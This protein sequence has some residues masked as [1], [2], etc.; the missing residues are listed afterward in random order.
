MTM[1]KSVRR[2]PR[3]SPAG[4]ARGA[5]PCVEDDGVESEVVWEAKREVEV[6]QSLG[7]LRPSLP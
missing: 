7:E 1:V 2:S 6:L 3:V 4:R 5:D